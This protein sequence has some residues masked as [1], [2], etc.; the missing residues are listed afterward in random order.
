MSDNMLSDIARIRH[1]NRAVS[2]EIGALD[3]S[4]LGRGRPLGAARVL[5]TIGEQGAVVS[6]LRE[7]L[8]LD[9]GLMSRLLRGLEDEGLITTSP[10]TSDGRRR[11]ARPTQAG[12]AEI[13]AYD[14]LSNKRAG[15]LLKL[16]GKHSDE[17]LD[18]MDRITTILGQHHIEITEVDPQSDMARFCLERY[19]KTLAERLETGFDVAQSCAPDSSE[20]TAPRGSFLV[21]SLEAAPL[22]CIGLKGNKTDTAEIK[23]LWI[24]PSARGLGLAGQLMKA[25]ETRARSLRIRTLRLDTNRAL[26]E[27]I[28]LYR[29]AGW[30]EIPAF[31]TEPYADHWFEKKL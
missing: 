23:R 24:A 13:E 16:S 10:C 18:A 15:R 29:R 1:F 3:H 11:I 27:A 19:Y 25:A 22:G 21:A 28:A 4:Y 17:L 6:D 20:M 26:T 9:S 30:S 12:L 7:A 2:T 31:N 14:A 8:D 5:C